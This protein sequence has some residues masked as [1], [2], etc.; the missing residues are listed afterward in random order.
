M[1]T[2]AWTTRSGNGLWVFNGTT[3]YVVLGVQ[4]VVSSIL[5]PRIRPLTGVTPNYLQYAGMFGLTNPDTAP[6]GGT[7]DYVAMHWHIM[8]AQQAQVV[9]GGN[10]FTKLWHRLPPGATYQFRL[11]Y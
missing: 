7:I 8:F 2:T 6:A 9:T 10:L 11:Y 4:V 3:G 1:P 5:S